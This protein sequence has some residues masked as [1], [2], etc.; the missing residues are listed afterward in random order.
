MISNTPSFYSE[1]QL[2]ASVERGKQDHLQVGG[3]C[4][5]TDACLCFYV[6]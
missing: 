2:F 4:Y 6:T 3:I 5:N 1:T